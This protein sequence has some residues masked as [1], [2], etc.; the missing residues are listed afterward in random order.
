M[1]GLGT[2]STEQQE[3]HEASDDGEPPGAF[4]LFD[5]PS[6]ADSV[7]W[8]LLS[9][10]RHRESANHTTTALKYR[11]VAGTHVNP[12]EVT[13]TET[14][15]SGTA[16]WL[17]AEVVGTLAQYPLE[18][19]DTEFPHHARSVDSAEGNPRPAERSPVFYG[20]Y[21]WHSAV[22]SH[23][24]LLRQLRLFD[25]HPDE[26]AVRRSIDDRVTGA[27]VATELDQFE[28]GS[29]EQPYGWAWFLRLAAELDAWD[30]PQAD[31]W[32]STLAPLEERIRELTRSEFLTQERPFRVGTHHNSAFALGAVLDYAAGVGDDDLAAATRETG[33]RFYAADTGYPLEYE[34]LGWDF[35]SPALTEANLM[36]RVLDSS[37]FQSW[38]ESFL[39]DVTERPREALPEPV[40]VEDDESGVALHFVGLNL[41]RAWCLADLATAL[42]GPT[43]AAPEDP[44]AAALAA[45][46]REHAERGVRGAVTDDYAGAHWLSSF[47]LYLCTR[48][49][50]A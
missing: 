43:A 48:H 35:L 38:F 41:S 34:P 29:F 13:D 15:L 7:N 11:T 24:C 23:W 22:H 42:D 19:V 37:E 31:E 32:R 16:D 3:R 45:S 46:A 30:D 25:G 36:R 39:P 49:H 2:E 1:R 14:L 40:A 10:V 50:G 28:D 27:N 47:V 44:T 12:L 6:T 5:V 8:S 18:S 20:S 4:S 33:R 17:T 26:A 21:D 9:G